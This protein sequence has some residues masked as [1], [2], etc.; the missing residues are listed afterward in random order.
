[1]A[2][3]SCGL[4]DAQGWCEMPPRLASMVRTM[5]CPFVK[6]AHI[7]HAHFKDVVARVAVESSDDIPDGA[8]ILGRLTLLLAYAARMRR[9]ADYGRLFIVPSRSSAARYVRLG[10]WHASPHRHNLD[11]SRLCGRRVRCGRLRTDANMRPH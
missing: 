2:G 9:I 6:T 10:R 3:R 1:V 7:V 4:P 11:L 5:L 8:C